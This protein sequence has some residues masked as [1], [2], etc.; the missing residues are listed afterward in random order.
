MID[1]SPLPLERQLLPFG[2]GAGRLARDV[3]PA[4]FL[5]T[6]WGHSGSIWLAGSLNLH[7]EV[8]ATVGFDNPIE[9]FTLYQ[10]NKDASSI[11]AD[12]GVPLSRYGFGVPDRPTFSSFRS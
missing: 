5:V 12:A 4:L 7:D 2:P 6:S 3:N 10:L 11:V 9:C 8:C 1:R